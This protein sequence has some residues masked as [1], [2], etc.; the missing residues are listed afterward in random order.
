M[1]RRLAVD[2]KES[3][4]DLE[5]FIKDERSHNRKERLQIL[6]LFKSGNARTLQKL[7]QCVGKSESTIKRWLVLYRQGGLEKLLT[8]KKRGG[9]EAILSPEML[10]S[11]EKRLYETPYFNSYGQVQHW[12]QKELEI[13][14]SY[15]T[16]HKSVRYRLGV[17]LKN[18]DRD[19]K[20]QKKLNSNYATDLNLNL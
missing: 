3:I 15:K 13:D 12:I 20:Y 5:R 4:Q 18:L 17:D 6:L 10:M 8:I 9:K 11:L 16:T 2:V 19:N 7:A 1:A 14:I